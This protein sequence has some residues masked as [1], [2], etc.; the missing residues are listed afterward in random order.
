[1]KPVLKTPGSMDLKLKYDGQLS[2]SAFNFDLRR[3]TPAVAA[4]RPAARPTSGRPASGRPPTSGVSS[5]AAVRSL[6]GQTVR[7]FPAGARPASA[8]STRKP[9]P[10]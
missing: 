4:V 9:A 7:P 2:N 6:Y 1:M 3:Y 5:A 8:P 10:R